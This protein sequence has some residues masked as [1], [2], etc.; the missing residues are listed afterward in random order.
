MASPPFWLFKLQLQRQRQCERN[1]CPWP[2]PQ[3]ETTRNSLNKV[4]LE[5]QTFQKLRMIQAHSSVLRLTGGEVWQQARKGKTGILSFARLFFGVLVLGPSGAAPLGK[6]QGM[7]RRMTPK[8]QTLTCFLL[9]QDAAWCS[10]P[11]AQDDPKGR[12]WFQ[13]VACA[14]INSIKGSNHISKEPS[15][16]SHGP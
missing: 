13:P 6:L 3:W 2:D 8:W 9:A 1:K 10:A 15:I 14:C 7:R 11:G 16:H 12:R 4:S 5:L